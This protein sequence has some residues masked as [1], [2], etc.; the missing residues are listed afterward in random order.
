MTNKHST[1]TSKGMIPKKN[2]YK[3]NCH[4]KMIE[5]HTIVFEVLLFSEPRLDALELGLPDDAPPTLLVDF[6]LGTA[7]CQT[8]KENDYLDLVTL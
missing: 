3:I 4:R 1:P 5:L 2:K 6:P 8:K 7:L